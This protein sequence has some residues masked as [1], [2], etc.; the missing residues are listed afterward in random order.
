MHHCP[1]LLLHTCY[2]LSLSQERQI[3][4]ACLSFS[5]IFVHRRLGLLRVALWEFEPAEGAQN[6]IFVHVQ[7]IDVMFAPTFCKLA[8]FRISLRTWDTFPVDSV[9]GFFVSYILP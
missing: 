9:I 2:V 8:G 1:R 5:S 6:T 4:V 3:Q 7:E